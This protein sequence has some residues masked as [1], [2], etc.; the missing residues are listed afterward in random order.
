MGR[1]ESREGAR[2]K[3]VQVARGLGQAGGEVL[4]LQPRE[5]ELRLP[6]PV[7]R[8]GR[9][10]QQGKINEVQ[11]LLARAKDE[12]HDEHERH[13]NAAAR[14]ARQ[15][16]HAAGVPVT[17]ISRRSQD[18]LGRRDGKKKKK[19][20]SVHGDVFENLAHEYADAHRS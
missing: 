2:A 12:S 6:Y 14:K 8:N 9:K 17:A 11:K 10:N 7:E 19:V 4:V 13:I 3:I 20:A 1:T 16:A 5:A 15:D 18:D